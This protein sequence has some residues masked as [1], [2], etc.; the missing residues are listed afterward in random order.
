MNPTSKI[1]NIISLLVSSQRFK[2]NAKFNLIR[3]KVVVDYLIP[4]LNGYVREVIIANGLD[5]DKPSSKKKTTAEHVVDTAN[6]LNTLLEKNGVNNT[7]GKRLATWICPK[8][9]SESFK[10]PSKHPLYKGPNKAKEV[11]EKLNVIISPVEEVTKKKPAKKIDFFERAGVE[12][13][14]KKKTN[15][16][17]VSEETVSN[18]QEPPMK[19]VK[20]FGGMFK[21]I[22]VK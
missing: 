4:Y 14:S 3:H 13:P 2:F 18:V 1:K 22:A 10:D 17:N 12:N 16:K 20:D 15:K 19:T 8:W 7:R 21:R 6:F 5:P 11:T 9:V